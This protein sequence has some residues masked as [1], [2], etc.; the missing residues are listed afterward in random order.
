VID[1]LTAFAEELRVIGIPVSMVEVL[2]AAQA[3]D[4]VDLSTS[5]GLRAALGA[6]M[7]KSGR[8][9]PAFDR[10][11]DVFFELGA[12]GQPLQREGPAGSPQP[13]GLPSSIADALDREDRDRLM[14]LIREAVERFGKLDGSQSAGGSYHAYRVLRRL[15]PDAIRELLIRS[16]GQRS[17][18]L[19]DRLAADRVD[20]LIRK[21]REEVHREA[22]RR[23]VEERGVAAVARSVREPLVED[24]D[25]QHATVAEIKAIEHAIAPLARKLATRLS[26]RRRHGRRGRLD[27]RATIRRSLAHGGALVDP[28]FRKPRIAKPQIVLLCDTSGSM[29]TFSRFTLQLTH[30]IA[31]ELSGVRSFVFVEGVDEVTDLFGANRD[32]EASLERIATAADVYRG[33][34]HSDY[35]GSFT[36][37]TDRYLDAVSPRTTVIVTG[38]ARTNY[39]FPA[40]DRFRMLSDRARAVFWLNPEPE[41]FWDTGDSAMGRYAPG[42][43]RVEEVRSLRQ[44]ERFIER[45]VLP[46]E[47]DPRP[48]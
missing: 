28:R 6:T 17:D 31:S 9:R 15:D 11:F 3:M 40:V 44:L 36:E 47:R 7:V 12:P 21:L 27:V 46:T 1:R 19:D 2:D 14:G 42:C 13:V 20:R 23:L 38:D 35:G 45:A 10:V 41:R 16:A 4:H 25:L 26:H 8:H 24:L 43:D 37:F 32:F 29:A 18:P 22:L 33:D 5:D 39:R 34:G 30:A 48:V